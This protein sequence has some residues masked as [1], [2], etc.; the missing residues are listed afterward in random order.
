MPPPARSAEAFGEI[1]SRSLM[2]ACAR[3]LEE[4]GCSLLIKSVGAVTRYK[5]H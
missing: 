5:W 4:H 3:Q 2:P 1:L